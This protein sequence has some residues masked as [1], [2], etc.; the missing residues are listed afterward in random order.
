ML[1]SKAKSN[2]MSEAAAK[3]DMD[4]AGVRSL[5]AAMAEADLTAPHDD[6]VRQLF[7]LLTA[8][9]EDGAVAAAEGQAPGSDPAKRIALANRLRSLAEE[10]SILTDAVI[11]LAGEQSA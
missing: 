8:R 9:F 3:L 10:V 4:F 6:L 1:G 5:R 11:A 7:Y 2:G